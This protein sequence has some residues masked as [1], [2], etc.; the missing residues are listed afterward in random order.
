TERWGSLD[1][2]GLTFRAPHGGVNM[3]I[4]SD[5]GMGSGN[6]NAIFTVKVG[7]DGRFGTEDDVMSTFS[8]SAPPFGYTE[9]EG[10]VSDPRGTSLFAASRERC[11]ISE[12]P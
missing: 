5:A 9:T 12:T 7:P 8:T 1:P 11:K 4:W 3:L 10:V 2:E 6:A